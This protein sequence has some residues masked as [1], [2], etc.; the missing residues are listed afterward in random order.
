M[1][2]DIFTTFFVC[3]YIDVVSLGNDIEDGAFLRL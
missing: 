1:L 2:P 3:I